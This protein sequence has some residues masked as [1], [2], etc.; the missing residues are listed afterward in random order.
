MYSFTHE[1]QLIPGLRYIVQLYCVMT[2]EYSNLKQSMCYFSAIYVS[3]TVNEAYLPLPNSLFSLHKAFIEFIHWY[4]LMCSFEVW[5]LISKAG[6]WFH[7]SSK[8]VTYCFRP[9]VCSFL[10]EQNPALWMSRTEHGER[11]FVTFHVKKNCLLNVAVEWLA[12]LI[13]IREVQVS[14]MIPETGHLEAYCGL[15]QALQ[16]NTS[17]IPSTKH[18]VI[19]SNNL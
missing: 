14:N 17:I 1:F 4:T 2:T 13:C 18:T 11:P 9:H 7:T 10:Y 3:K 5:S 19:P 16:A 6:L 12:F 15:P 8:R